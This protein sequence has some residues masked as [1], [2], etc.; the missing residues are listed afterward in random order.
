[1]TLSKLSDN[2]K[3]PDFSALQRCACVFV[4][5]GALVLDN[6]VDIIMRVVFHTLTSAVC[7]CACVRVRAYRALTCAGLT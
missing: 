1:M 3:Q 2:S 6:E 4:C 7:V 5:V